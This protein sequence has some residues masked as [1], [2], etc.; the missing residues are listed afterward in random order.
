M[1]GANLGLDLE[2]SL[3][4]AAVI[5]V[6]AAV[7]AEQQGGAGKGCASVVYVTIGTGIGAGWPSLDG[8]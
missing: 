7:L 3:G 8:C 4:I 1:D 2:S 5:D 6:N